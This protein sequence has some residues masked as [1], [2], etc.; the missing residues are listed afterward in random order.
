MSQDLIIG[1]TNLD[2]SRSSTNGIVISDKEIKESMV[3]HHRH[4]HHRRGQ[5]QPGQ[6]PGQYPG[7]YQAP[8]T[9]TVRPDPQKL[10][11]LRS[12]YQ[13]IKTG[14]LNWLT[15]QDHQ[16]N[17]WNTPASTYQQA[18]KLWAQQQ[19]QQQQLPIRSDPTTYGQWQQS[20][21]WFQT[22]TQ[23]ALNSAAGQMASS[24]TTTQQSTPYTPPYT[25]PA[26]VSQY[27]SPSITVPTVPQNVYYPSPGDDS[28][29][30]DS[31]RDSFVADE[32]RAER[33]NRVSGCGDSLPHGEYRAL[34]MNQAIKNA[35][36]KSPT[37]KHLFAAKKAVDSALGKSGTGIYIPGAAPRRRTV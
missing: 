17:I 29:D 6:V 2:W 4:H 11:L 7:Q 13:Q 15:N 28:Y 27:A 18:A 33:E 16:N 24:I 34:V 37:T 32:A 26:P 21:S 9:G 22:Q 19:L 12:T 5:W 31:G 20:L 35:G 36:G 25:P 10:Q 30:D 23:A 1:S 8:P 14:H 3:G